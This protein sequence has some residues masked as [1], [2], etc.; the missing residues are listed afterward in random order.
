MGPFSLFPAHLNCCG[1]RTGART[2]KMTRDLRARTCSCWTSGSAASSSNSSS[3]REKRKCKAKQF[4]AS[5]KRQQGK[6]SIYYLFS[7]RLKLAMRFILDTDNG[8]LEI[9]RRESLV[10]GDGRVPRESATNQKYREIDTGHIY[11]LDAGHGELL[12]DSKVMDFFEQEVKLLIQ[13]DQAVAIGA[14]VASDPALHQQFVAKRLLIS[15]TPSGVSPASFS[16]EVK[17]KVAMLNLEAVA[18][19][20]GEASPLAA[21]RFGRV[22]EDKEQNTAAARVLYKSAAVL[23]ESEMDPR[24]L[25][26]LGLI[27]LNEKRFEEAATNLKKAA[28]KAEEAKDP[29][30]TADLKGK[31]YGNLG[32]ALFHAGFPKEAR[33]AYAA[34]KDNPIAQRNLDL[35]KRRSVDIP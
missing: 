1:R 24:T 4:N 6:D 33:E 5:F 31:I 12:S 14:Y 15:P 35:L 11:Q 16:Q 27:L 32:T 8:S 22:L 13:R 25:N 21:K 26:R 20:S 17:K 7:S 19:S 9:I 29:Y 23:D 10:G 28:K 3:M 2:S 30:L 18:P 34:A